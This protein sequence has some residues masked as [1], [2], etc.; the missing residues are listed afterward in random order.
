[1]VLDPF[2]DPK[3]GAWGWLR[4]LALPTLE[5]AL[6]LA[7]AGRAHAQELERR[8][9]FEG[10]LTPVPA[11]AAKTELTALAGGGGSSSSLASWTVGA[12]DG[13]SSSE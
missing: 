2:A 6:A 3:L 9:A 4:C 1:V 8:G 10:L 5:G 7:E 11:V 13:S 12:G